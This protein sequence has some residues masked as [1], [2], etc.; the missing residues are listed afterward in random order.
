MLRNGNSESAIADNI[1][2]LMQQGKSRAEATM[3]ATVHAIKSQP[4]RKP[5][6]KKRT[7]SK[8]RYGRR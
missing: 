4:V 5:A 8:P 3:I 7:R 6:K 1:A 2:T